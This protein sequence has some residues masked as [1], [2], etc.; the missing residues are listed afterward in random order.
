[1]RSFSALFPFLIG[2]VTKPAAPPVEKRKLTMP[3]IQ[4]VGQA[5][6]P[7]PSMD[8]GNIFKS[9]LRKD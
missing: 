9:F 8:F 3:K 2:K 1:M 7:V 6:P 5:S 4:F